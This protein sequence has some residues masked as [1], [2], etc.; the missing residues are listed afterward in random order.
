MS[1][2]AF[3][4]TLT[5]VGGTSQQ[6]E[7]N[8]ITNPIAQSSTSDWTSSNVTLSRVATGSPLD[9]EIPTGFQAVSTTTTTSYV[10]TAL[11][12]VA[13]SLRNRKLKV[14]FYLALTDSTS[15]KVDV[16]KSDGVTR[17]PLST[18]SSA[19]TVIPALTGT[20]TTT[21]DMDSDTGIYVRFT[22][23]AGSGT[24][25]LNF[26]NL[27]VG[28]GIQP[29]G[30]GVEEWQSYSMTITG[31]TSNPTK[32]T[33]SLDQARYRRVGDSMEIH[34]DYRQTAAG[35]AGSGTYYFSLPSGFTID[36][37]KFSTT[38][39]NQTG[40]VGPASGR[41]STGV[42][43]YGIVSIVNST[44]FILNL[45]ND[46]NAGI[47]PGSGNNFALSGADVRFSFIA[48]VPIAQWAGSGTVQL[49]QNDVSYYYGTGGT[50]GT[51]ATVTTAQGPGGVLG[52]TTTPSGVLFEWTIVPPSPIQIGS[53]PTLEFS[54]DGKNWGPG[55][56]TPASTTIEN[57]RFDGTNWIGAGV[58]LNN[59]GNIIIRWG[60]YAYGTVG[61]YTGAWYWRVKVVAP[62]AA[63]GFGI[64]QGTSAGLV[65]ASNTN[66]DDVTATR[67][68]LKQY[69]HGTTYNGGI[70]PTVTCSQAGFAVDKAVFIP[71]QMQDGVWRLRLNIRA[72]WT[73]ASVTTIIY[74]INGI[75]AGATIQA[76]TGFW[77]GVGT[78]PRVYVDASANNLYLN[79]QTATSTSAGTVA[80]DIELSSKPTW[81]Y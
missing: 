3:S 55:G 40:T 58:G 38:V 10:Q 71:Y 49:A 59:L 61:T 7:I 78:T 42:E 45:F 32:G 17:Y 72:S 19:V 39:F 74:T 47:A 43:L 26:T 75:T 11:Q 24:S 56:F 13:P 68:G 9:P 22:R 57:L 31:T 33:I 36:N 46:A 14:Q 69:L 73:L 65:P 20:F 1:S 48:T 64:V 80:A 2:S 62:G 27:I 52:G 51:T 79:A 21:F 81:A 18:D 60:K 76:G 6:G 12:N 25:I 28:P 50:W 44:Q 53:I 8:I 41:T 23:H 35:S 67:L 34:Y 54:V 5:V 16:F 63:V 4:P 29:Q 66:F 70:A 15:W 30:A 37:S 77:G